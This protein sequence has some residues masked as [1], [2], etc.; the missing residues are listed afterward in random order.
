MSARVTSHVLEVLHLTTGQDVRVSQ[1][2]VEVLI[3]V[4][5]R[6]PATP[7]GAG[8][9]QDV[10]EVLWAPSG[11]GRVTQHVIEV[12]CLP[13]I[14]TGSGGGGFNAMTTSFGFAS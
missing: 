4:I 13:E 5:T 7:T 11:A 3:P 1:D 8:V 12:L 14:G 6:S 10:V 2:V 9:T